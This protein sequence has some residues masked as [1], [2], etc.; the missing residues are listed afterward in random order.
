VRRRHDTSL[1]Q[2]LQRFHSFNKSYNMDPVVGHTLSIAQFAVEV[3]GTVDGID[4]AHHVPVPAGKQYI[5][6]KILRTL[7]IFLGLF[8][9]RQMSLRSSICIIYDVR[10][11]AAAFHSTLGNSRDNISAKAV[12]LLRR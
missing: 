2:R 9:S 11:V 12:R 3:P 5:A 10:C 1:V 7:L 4:H 8:S 6:M